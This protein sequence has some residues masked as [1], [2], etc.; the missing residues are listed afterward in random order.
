[1]NKPFRFVK[2]TDGN[3]IYFENP[4]ENYIYD[5]Q[6]DEYV[7][8][9]NFAYLIN[10]AGEKSMTSEKYDA[11]TLR[12]VDLDSGYGYA[13]FDANGNDLS[14]T[15]DVK[16]QQTITNFKYDE[17]TG[18]LTL[19]YEVIM[20]EYTRYNTTAHQLT[21]KGQVEV[22]VDYDKLINHAPAQ[23]NIF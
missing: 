4:Y 7:Y 2:D 5:P 18:L 6:T 13:I 15:I 21:I 23:E 3:T 16:N 12:I 1:M 9:G 11:L 14:E 22:T 17:A 8:Y 10:K 19:D 20:H